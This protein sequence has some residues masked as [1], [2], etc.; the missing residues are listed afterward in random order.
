MAKQR[1]W[2]DVRAA[3]ERAGVERRAVAAAMG[4]RAD[5]FS[6]LTNERASR[7]T[8]EWYAAFQTALA[9]LTAGVA[10]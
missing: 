3:M 9:G 6:K 1:T 7:P 10:K 8:A 5:Q 2:G 4:Y